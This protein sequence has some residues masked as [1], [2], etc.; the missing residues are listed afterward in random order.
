MASG[1]ESPGPGSEPLARVRV[2]LRGVG[3]DLEKSSEQSARGAALRP[4]GARR[5][6]AKPSWALVLVCPGGF[7]HREDFQG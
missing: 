4:P 2:L 7:A 6:A 1:V 5:E 3:A